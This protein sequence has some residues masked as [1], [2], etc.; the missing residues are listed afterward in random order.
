M[1]RIAG[2]WSDDIKEKILSYPL[3][4]SN[5]LAAYSPEITT[6]EVNGY[7]KDILGRGRASTLP[8]LT[9]QQQQFETTSTSAQEEE[10]ELQ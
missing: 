9:L 5:H 2:I 7:P 10:E 3:G 4:V 1:G 8:T 6:V